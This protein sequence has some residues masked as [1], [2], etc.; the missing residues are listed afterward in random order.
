MQSVQLSCAPSL[1][2]LYLK[3]ILKHKSTSVVP[4]SLPHLSMSLNNV[5]MEKGKLD[6]Y[7]DACGFTASANIPVTYP[8]I[9]AFPLHMSLL[10]DENCPFPMLGII[11]IK[12]EI[13]QRRPIS[14]D[15]IINIECQFGELE[16][17][18]KGVQFDILTKIT[19]EDEL[20]WT[21][22]S[23]ILCPQKN[24]E[25]ENKKS[26]LQELVEYSN[27]E[28]W[29]LRS[30]TGR[31]YASA[32]GDI[33]PIH[34]SSFSARLFGFK[35][36]IAHG[37]W[38]KAKALSVMALPS[39]PYKVT[40]SFK[41]PVYLPSLVSFSSETTQEGINFLLKNNDSGVPHLSGS[42]TYITPEN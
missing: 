12:N 30:N 41:R 8:H 35:H 13:T 42:L 3:V 17:V 4:P 6:K 36:A 27:T 9:L 11:H 1:W 16:L 2:A 37:M 29:Q 33:N 24:I 26:E 40:A 23:T 31:R 5:V 38:S 22:A 21:S 25:Q 39:G 7:I 34:L 32:S 19:I 18:D 14:K 20:V 15:E 28:S 10:L